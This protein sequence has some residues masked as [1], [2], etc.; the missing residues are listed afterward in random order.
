MEEERVYTSLELANE[1][2]NRIQEK[3]EYRDF[4][5]EEGMRPNYFRDS[6]E[7]F[8]LEDFCLPR[9]RRG[10]L[11]NLGLDAGFLWQH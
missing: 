9:Y 4:E 10:S 6:V 11:E 5:V 8:I 7:W 3:R 2:T 1:I